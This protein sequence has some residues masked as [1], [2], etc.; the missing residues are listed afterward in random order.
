[1]V[2]FNK[3]EAIPFSLFKK[4]INKNRKTKVNRKTNKK[5]RSFNKRKYKK[6]QKKYFNI[7]KGVIIR[8]KN[9]L[10]KSI[11]KKLILLS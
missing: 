10:Y 4:F 3:K 11:G 7:P 6:T 1:M 8:K 2:N 9:K 5:K